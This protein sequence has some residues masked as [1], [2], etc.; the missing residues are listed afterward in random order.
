MV[1]DSASYHVLPGWQLRVS[2]VFHTATGTQWQQSDLAALRAPPKSRRNSDTHSPDWL[3]VLLN[4]ETEYG[5]GLNLMTAM[6][7]Y[8]DATLC[9]LHAQLRRTVCQVGALAC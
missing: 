7:M 3:S 9:K 1:I 5:Y 8:M 2:G 4:A 6:R